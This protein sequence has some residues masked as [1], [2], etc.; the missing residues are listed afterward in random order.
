M[1]PVDTPNAADAPF[2][3]LSNPV[4]AVAVVVAIL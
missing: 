1:P 4:A 3:A 2:S